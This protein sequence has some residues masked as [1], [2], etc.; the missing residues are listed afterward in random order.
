MRTAL[1]P[2]ISFLFHSK[3]AKGPIQEAIEKKIEEKFGVRVLSV[4]A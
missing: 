4:V 2:A 3:K 1:S